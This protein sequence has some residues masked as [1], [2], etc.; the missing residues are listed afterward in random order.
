MRKLRIVALLGLLVLLFAGTGLA[1]DGNYLYSG[2]SGTQHWYLYADGTLSI[3]GS[4]YVSYSYVGYNDWR[5]Y[6]D[7]ITT[8]VVGEGITKLSMSVFQQLPALKTVYLPS[9]LEESGTW[10][11]KDCTAL[12]QVTFAPGAKEI[13]ARMFENCTSLR[14][15]TMGSGIQT[16]GEGAF[17]GCTSLETISLPDTVTSIGAQAFNESGLRSFIVP[18]EVTEIPLGAFAACVSLTTVTLPA[19]LTA[20]GD[21]A[22]TGCEALQTI[23]LPDGLQTIDRGAFYGCTS[24]SAMVVPSQVT[25]VGGSAWENCTGLTSLV[26]PD[27][28]LTLGESCLKNSGYFNRGENWSDGLLYLGN[29]LI[30][31]DP[32]TV[33]GSITLRE[34]ILGMADGAFL[35][36]TAV[37]SVQLPQTVTRIPQR[38][39]QGCTGLEMPNIQV[40]EIGISAFGGCTALTSVTLGDTVETVGRE[41]FFDC[42]FLSQ[43]TVENPELSIGDYAFGFYQG[44][45]SYEAVT[46]FVLRADDNSTAHT[47]ATNYTLFFQATGDAPVLSG[48]CGENLT[49]E[50]VGGVLTISGTGPMDDCTWDD[51]KLIQPWTDT[52]AI[53]KVIVEEGVTRIGD[54]AFADITTLTQVSLPSTL[55]EIGTEAFE[56]TSIQELILP[57]NSALTTIKPKAFQKAKHLTTVELPETVTTIGEEAF[58]ECTSLRTISLPDGLKTLGE[59]AFRGC[60][61]LTEITLPGTIGSVPRGCFFGC[62]SLQKVTMEEGISSIQGYA[63]YSCAALTDITW[64]SSIT[65]I[66]EYALLGARYLRRIDLPDGVTKVGDRAFEDCLNL[67]TVSVPSA[68]TEVGSAVFYRTQYYFDPANWTGDSLYWG[69]FLVSGGGLDNPF[70]DVS[71]ESYYE[72]SVLWAVM[73]GVTNGIDD[74]HFSPEKSCTRAEIVTFLWRAAGEPGASGDN[75]FVDVSP[76]A[77]YETAVRWAVEN[78]ITTGRDATHFDPNATCTRAEA[79]TFLWRAAGKPTVET[80]QSMFTDVAAEVYYQEAV[81]WA[82]ES[83]ITNGVTETTFCPGATCTRAQIVTFLYRDYRASGL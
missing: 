9:T 82:V 19:G 67:A 47:Y 80:T 45:T 31:A 14:T 79:V 20:I 24:L 8:I 52:V 74:T 32:E 61:A 27:S 11:F 18:P 33:S 29:F 60:T 57:E 12:E 22:F 26:L 40:K 16:V 71:K 17:L 5:K 1:T 25:K 54:Y 36:C 7:Q 83:G 35:D 69:S 39:F 78:G 64:S 77:C 6:A 63:F 50:Q 10:T 65:E 30:A 76:V 38:A 2:T 72:S 43:V 3:Q 51:W 70:V 15:V 46:P 28:I 23:N 75:P 44:Q 81:A 62:A 13:G 56:E 4:G 58:L 49:W 37:T 55:T 21:S 66:G 48:T 41:A 73:R 59:D 53:S 68:L 42:T 34:G